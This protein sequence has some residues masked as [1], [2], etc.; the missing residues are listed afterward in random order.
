MATQNC[1]DRPLRFSV[2][3][4]ETILTLEDCKADPIEKMEGK[5]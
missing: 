3:G 5:V 1:E 2:F 4:P